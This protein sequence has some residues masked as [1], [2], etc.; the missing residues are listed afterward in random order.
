MANLTPFE[1]ERLLGG[2]PEHICN[3][4][5]SL[6]IRQKECLVLIFV[7]GCTEE[8]AATKLGITRQAVGKHKS[9]GIQKLQEMFH[10]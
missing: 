5:A 6:T 10:R 8:E 3:A 2:L 4:V 7:D 9:I 1:I